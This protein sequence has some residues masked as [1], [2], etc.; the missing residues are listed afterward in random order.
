MSRQPITANDVYKMLKPLMSIPGC[1]IEC[2]H[3]GT[4][5]PPSDSWEITAG[6]ATIQG[7]STTEAYWMLRGILLL[8][9]GE[10]MRFNQ[11]SGEMPRF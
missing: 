1:N 10:A 2:I 3:T 6:N 5:F 8:K 4:S 11:L 9:E 7:L